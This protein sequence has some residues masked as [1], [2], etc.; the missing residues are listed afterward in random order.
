MLLDKVKKYYSEEY[1]LNCAE[2]I[3]YAAN[4]EYNLN[5]DKNTLKTM[6]AFGGGMGIEGTCG[7]VSGSLAILGIIFTKEKA[8]ESDRIKL[9]SQEFFKSFE[10]KLKSNNC[11]SLKEMY[12]NDDVR[13]SEIV[14]T[15]AEVLEKIIIREKD[16]Q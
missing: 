7:V 8:H 12:R 1:D 2:T 10:E 15:A 11:K 4:E 9:L 13:C 6:S 14:Y 5:L 3:V 16:N